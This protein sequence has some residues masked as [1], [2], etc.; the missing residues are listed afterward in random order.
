MKDALTS[1]QEWLDENQEAEKDEFA[2]K[3]KEVQDVCNPIIAEAYK[4]AGGPEG[5]GEGGEEEDLGE[6]DEL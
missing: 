5:A 6:H 1:A 2:D 3:L 4:A